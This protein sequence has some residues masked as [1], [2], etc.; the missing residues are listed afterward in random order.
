MAEVQIKTVR[1]KH[2]AIMNFIIANPT[3][4]YGQVAAEFN[5]TPA[6]LSVIVNSS[7]FQDRLK[8]KQEK[9]YEASVLAP[10]G[11]KLAAAADLTLE[12]YLEKVPTLSGDQ[13]I[14]ASD[15]LLNRLGYGTKGGNGS[16]HIGQMNVQ[17]NSN[18]VP[19]E[20]IEQARR[21]IGAGS[22][23]GPADR[24]SAILHQTTTERT[25][26]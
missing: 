7:A 21:K 23:M 19:R 11:D 16:T 2:E 6:W 18:H 24:S 8:E 3:L 26:T 10:L 15:K 5:V 13:L 20:V 22:Q 1:T 17:V 25:E 14:S 4:T 9:L 12:K